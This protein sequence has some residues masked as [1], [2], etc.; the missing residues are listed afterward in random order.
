MR[1]ELLP[2]EWVRA[3]RPAQRH[4]PGFERPRRP[5]LLATTRWLLAQSVRP[6]ARRPKTP[7]PRGQMFWLRDDA[8]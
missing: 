4:L 8:P 7:G 5:R 6:R 3:D 2:F 1:R